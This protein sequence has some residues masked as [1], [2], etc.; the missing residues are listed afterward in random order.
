M[1]KSILLGDIIP[2]GLVPEVNGVKAKL[3]AQNV[4]VKAA[5]KEEPES[6][7]QTLS[8]GWFLSISSNNCRVI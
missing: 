4:H 5:V 2:A 3:P 7:S 8:F 6:R 1:G